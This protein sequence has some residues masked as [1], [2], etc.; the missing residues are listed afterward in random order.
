MS[1]WTIAA[2]TPVMLFVV[3]FAGLTVLLEFEACGLGVYF[4]ALE[5]MP[6]RVALNVFYGSVFSYQFS[7]AGHDS[8]A[9]AMCCV[10]F[11]LALFYIVLRVIKPLDLSEALKAV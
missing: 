2:R 11:V 6:G 4:R 8:W 9:I 7:V 1:G 5:T 3:F 10:Y